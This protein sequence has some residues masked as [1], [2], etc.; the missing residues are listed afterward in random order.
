MNFLICTAAECFQKPNIQLRN[1]TSRKISGVRS[2]GSNVLLSGDNIC[3]T[4]MSIYLDCMIIFIMYVA[5]PIFARY[6]RS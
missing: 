2:L 3:R 1:P 6:F 4:S 5:I